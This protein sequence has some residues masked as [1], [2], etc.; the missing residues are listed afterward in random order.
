MAKRTSRRGG[1]TNG[2]GDNGGGQRIPPNRPQT[3]MTNKCRCL[4]MT[5]T[6][7]CVTMY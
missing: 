5:K 2:G 7:L 4:Q 3:H 6:V 1:C